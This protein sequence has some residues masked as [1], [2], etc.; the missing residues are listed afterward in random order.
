MKKFAETFVWRQPGLLDYLKHRITNTPF[1]GI[2]K[3]VARI[4]ANVYS[5]SCF[6]ILRTR[7]LF[8]ILDISPA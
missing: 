5:L 6:G 4:I 8:G 2:K 3:K 7:V 1:E